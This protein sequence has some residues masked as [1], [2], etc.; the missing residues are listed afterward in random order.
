MS[1][2]QLSRKKKRRVVFERGGGLDSERLIDE[3]I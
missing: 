2:F 1:Q 3:R